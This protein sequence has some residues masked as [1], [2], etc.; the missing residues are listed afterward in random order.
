MNSDLDWVHGGQY[1]EFSELFISQLKQMQAVGIDVKVLFDGPLHD[2]KEQTR[3]LR[4]RGNIDRLHN[5]LRNMQWLA[6]KDTRS[7]HRNTDEVA[8][9]LFVIPLLALDACVEALRYHSIPFEFCEGEADGEVARQARN[10]D[11]FVLSKDS[12][13]YVYNL[14][15]AKY[16]P[17]D[18]LTIT[19]ES[20]SAVSYSFSKIAEHFGLEPNM[21]PIFASILGNDYLPLDLFES[22]IKTLQNEGQFL[23]KNW[24]KRAAAFLNHHSKDMSSIDQVI[25]RIISSISNLPAGVTEQ[26]L[27]ETMHESI[28]QYDPECNISSTIPVSPTE[29]RVNEAFWSVAKGRY[30]T[31]QCSYKILDVIQNRKFWCTPFIEDMDRESSWMISRQLRQWTYS[32]ILAQESENFVPE[33]V[34]EYVRHANHVG[35]DAVNTIPISGFAVI[36]SDPSVTL[37][38]I[39]SHDTALPLFLRLHQCNHHLLDRKLHPT[40]LFIIAILRYLINQGATPMNSDHTV[41]KFSNHEIVALIVSSVVSLAPTLWPDQATPNINFTASLP[42]RR[43][44]QI[45]AQLQTTLLSSYLLA[46]ALSL[47]DYLFPPPSLSQ[48]YNG[49][50]LHHYL[51]SAK[52][53]ATIE[54]MVGK[55]PAVS[56]MCHQVLDFVMAGWHGH[57]VEIVFQY[58]QTGNGPK[59]SQN[60]GKRDSS[61]KKKQKRS[62]STTENM[63]D[64]LSSGCRW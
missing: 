19:S 6:L 34:I 15:N 54:R 57:E 5:V 52:G 49:Q 30:T 7:P 42:T 16:I 56:S 60:D 53:G 2:R 1:S 13:F 33:T 51:R 31:G 43:G 47:D 44:L 27:L 3:L 61:T 8:Q 55:Q 26:D 25:E 48:Y 35:K 11:G 12:D 24:F 39:T 32:I 64:V 41:H 10:V 46:Q 20:V 9:H 36:A 59:K 45:T 38:T 17:L 18:M 28:R 23:P 4:H 63:F 37:S 29:I 40:I 22:S 50:S 14:G 62:G 21:M 58:G